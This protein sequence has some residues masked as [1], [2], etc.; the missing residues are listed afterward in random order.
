MVRKLKTGWAGRVLLGMALMLAASAVAWSAEDKTAQDTQLLRQ[1][2]SHW[3][4]LVNETNP[5][6]RK[7][8]VEAH[9]KMMV[10]VKANQ[11]TN[12][13]QPMGSHRQDG[14]MAHHRQRDLQNTAEM[15]MM[16]LDMMQ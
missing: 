15:H 7:L 6:K 14:S 11:P 5:D 16:L 2:E 1:L 8:L 3:Q 4:G 13:V 9:R 10:E 12:T